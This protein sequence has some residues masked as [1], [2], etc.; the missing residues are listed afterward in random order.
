MFK[1]LLP[2]NVPVKL[3]TAGLV[4]LT[5]IA[6]LAL[7]VPLPARLLRVWAAA[8]VRVPPEPV[9]TLP[10]SVAA[11]VDPVLTVRLVLPRV[12]VPPLSVVMLAVAPLRLSVPVVRVVM[13][14]TPLTVVEPLLLLNEVIAAASV[15]VLVPPVTEVELRVFA[16][17][18][19]PLKVPVSRPTTVTVPALTPPVM[20]ALLPK[21]VEPAPASEARV[22]VPEPLVKFR[23]LAV[24]LEFVTAPAMVR[25]VPL[26]VAVPVVSRVSGAEVL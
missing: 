23:E 24:V 16:L 21:R 25:A 1:A 17:T 8:T 9:L 22:I 7:T 14:A 2:V 20:V 10:E 18:V 15:M 19:P 11:L 3:L 5:V 13:V 26:I 4:L 6:A 12:T